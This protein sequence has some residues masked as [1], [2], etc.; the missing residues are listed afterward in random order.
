MDTA[1]CYIKDWRRKEIMEDHVVTWYRLGHI[2]RIRLLR[3]RLV[4]ARAA[5]TARSDRED[6]PDSASDMGQYGGLQCHGLMSGGVQA[7]TAHILYHWRCVG[8]SI[9]N[10]RE[11]QFSGS[12]RGSFLMTRTGESPGIDTGYYQ[13]RPS[14]IVTSHCVLL[15]WVLLTCE[16]LTRVFL[17]RPISLDKPLFN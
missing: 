7:L 2:L 17:N 15:T 4:T 9:G 5:R 13:I 11:F 16:L 14:R 10:R 8:L 6:E 3:I 1:T 12:V